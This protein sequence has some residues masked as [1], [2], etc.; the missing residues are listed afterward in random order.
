MSNAL[1][2]DDYISEFPEDIQLRLNKLR[3]VI[4]ETAPNAEETISYRMPTFKLNGNL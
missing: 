2:I 3:Q 4:N 1:K